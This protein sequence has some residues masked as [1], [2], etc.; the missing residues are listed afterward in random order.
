MKNL[1]GIRRLLGQLVGLP[2][3]VAEILFTLI[4]FFL[5]ASVLGI[6]FLSSR[7]WPTGGD[8]ASHLLYV[9]LY[10]DGLLQSGHVMPWVP[11]VF[12]GFPF[13][14]YY[15]PLPFIT[16]AFLSKLIGIA[17]AFKWGG[18]LAAMLL[19]GAVLVGSRRWLQFGWMP[20][21]F[22]AIGALSF[23][24]H[25][26]NS[27]WGGNLLSTLAGEFSYS[28]G[29][30]FLVLSMMAWSRAVFTGKGWILAGI[31]EA[32]CGFSHGFPLLVVGFSTVF[33]LYEGGTFKRSLAMLV[34][35]H[36]LAFCLLA[37]W[38]WPMIEMHS[39]T[40]PNDG[41]FP[42]TDWRDMLP[43]TLW[44]PLAA[45]I[46][47][48]LLC[49]VPSVRCSWGRRQMQAARYFSSAAA[50]A[51]VAFIAGSQLG[52]ADIR[53]FPMT[54]LLGVIVC[55]WLFGQALSSFKWPVP[56]T[57]L[58]EQ[59]GSARISKQKSKRARKQ[60]EL[61]VAASRMVS[62]GATEVPS[63]AHATA[64]TK[65]VLSYVRILLVVAACFG[66]LA[67]LS[68]HVNKAPDWGLWNHSGL[69]AKPQWHNLS[70][71]FPAL[72]GDLWSPRLVF[73]HDPDNN[74]IGSTRSMEALPMFLN[75]RPVTEGLYM[76]SAIMGPAIYQL[77]SEISARPSSPLARFP[78]GSLDPV[79]AAKHMNFFHADTV[80]LRS[81]MAK[82]AI[83]KSGLFD[84]VAESF[85]FAVYKLKK[86]DS[87][88]AQVLTRPV[89]LFPKKDWMQASFLW[90]R[91][92]ASFDRYQP[93][94]ETDP[95][96]PTP[97]IAGDS[98]GVREV[99]LSRHELVF[100]TEAIGR[101]HL[102]KI[103]YHPRWQLASKGKI[104]IAAPGFMLVTPEEKE[105]RLVYGHT[106]IGKLGIAVTCAAFLFLLFSLC[107]LFWSRR[108]EAFS[109]EVVSVAETVTPNRWLA[110]CLAW[111][112]LL[113]SGFYF[114][115]HSPE[116]VYQQAW[117]LMRADK[118]ADAADEFERALKYRKSPAQKEEALFWLAKAQERA[119]HHSE[120]KA[121]L[122]DLCDHY[123]GYWLPESLFTL[124]LIERQEGHYGEAEVLA[125]RLREEYPNNQW[126]QKLKE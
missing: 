54:W 69:D 35:G 25:E 117:E 126:T 74:D 58:L 11:E 109:D 37:G 123:Q 46:A 38:L 110:T 32:A 2:A 70:K 103:A 44:V 100:E 79:M 104:S 30:L 95:G 92:A 18:F 113:V 81:E 12:A 87:H 8:A 28:Y 99:K 20:S 112:A 60:N 75:H 41:S 19:P 67:W 71:L 53:F 51:A 125:L 39:L 9:W 22:A 17:P 59:P 96:T 73:E 101:P 21:L 1:S 26:Q 42:V 65:P 64:V 24:F 52:L 57:T 80:L 94:Y 77:Q 97:L 82:E 6:G 85:P 107:S 76:E 10:A 43:A 5:I 102:I 40:V 66:Q 16:M 108:R 124:S 7:N 47:G 27:I 89:R 83:Q 120:A 14:S 88:L 72:T 91:N 86:F 78:S 23:V 31:L 56:S 63:Y 48:L 115:T 55:G 106:F 33:L 50:L 3:W 122:R 116:G 114:Y 45:G 4:A 61:A 62:S 49:L 111:F 13:L 118:F 84:K 36:V 34:Y 105:I 90:F 93:V 119:G 15:F 29:M 98:M 68:E 121:A